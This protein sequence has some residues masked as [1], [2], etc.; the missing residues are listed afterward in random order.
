MAAFLFV[1][2]ITVSAGNQTRHSVFNRPAECF[3]ADREIMYT[4]NQKMY[5]LGNHLGVAVPRYVPPL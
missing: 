3:R 5:L 4:R 1:A 2:L